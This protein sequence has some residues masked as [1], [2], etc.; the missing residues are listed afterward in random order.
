MPLRPD[1]AERG[2]QEIPAMIGTCRPT[3]ASGRDASYSDVVGLVASVVG[4][5]YLTWLGGGNMAVEAIIEGGWLWVTDE[6]D[7]FFGDRG[8][9]TGW[10][11]GVYP[12]SP[13]ADEV[14]YPRTFVSAHGTGLNTLR[15]ILLD[16][17]RRFADTR[18]VAAPDLVP[19]LGSALRPNTSPP[20]E[21]TSDEHH[22]RPGDRRPGSRRHRL[23][24]PTDRTV[25][26]RCSPSVIPQPGCR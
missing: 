19:S 1:T 26:N 14:R 25:I 7:A 18:A 23:D 9:E 21:E 8:E 17:L 22:Q 20:G 16:A 12:G 13:L 15:A 24:A 3:R 2:E 11:V 5:A 10:S 4:A 6:D